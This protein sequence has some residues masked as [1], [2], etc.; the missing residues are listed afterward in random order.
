VLNTSKELIES[1]NH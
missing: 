1:I